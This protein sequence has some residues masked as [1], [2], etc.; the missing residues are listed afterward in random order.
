MK[1]EH[2]KKGIRNTIV[3][4]LSEIVILI[5]GLI[6]P[7]VIVASYGS[8]VNGLLTSTAQLMGYLSIFEAGISTIMSNALYS[9]FASNDLSGVC[10]VYSAGNSYYKKATLYYC[11]G[12]VIA[13][14]LY[15][16]AI[17]TELPSGTVLLVVLLSGLGNVITFL[18]L[19]SMK[20]VIASDGNYYFIAIMNLVIKT[21]TY[22]V[23]ILTALVS[24][25]VIIIKSASL[26]V[27][28]LQIVMYRIYFKKKYNWITQTKCLTVKKFDN[29][30]YYIVH[31]VASLL[32]SCT[33]VTL[34]TFFEGLTVVSIYTIYN[35]VMSAISTLMNAVLSSLLF[36][37]G[38]TY[39][40]DLRKYCKLHDS[41]KL[42]YIEINSII[43]TT[44]YYMFI[45]FINIYMEGADVNY[46][47][48][49][50]AIMF[51][52]ISILN[53]YRI[54]DNNLASISWH[55]KQTI[56]HVVIE[57]V[58]NLALSMI[59]VVPLKIYGVLIGT[60]IAII[61]RVLVSP[62][63]SE[64]KI[65]HRKIING[66]KYMLVNG[67]LFALLA[68][69]RNSVYIQAKNYYELAGYGILILVCMIFAYVT[70]NT[71][72]FSEEHK[73][74]IKSLL[75]KNI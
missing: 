4:I 3:S 55:A 42:C 37:L 27:T 66:Y 38:Q 36:A 15:T 8:E 18:F 54:I 41:F 34:L 11:I 49:Y 70:I 64:K 72:F 62:Y 22:G 6:V 59:L 16:F 33:D 65:L 14:F 25:D 61:Y 68:L 29:R 40:L 21:L 58:I 23:T 50:I 5:L 73:Y 10:D 69:L 51:C 24:L 45:P 60:A 28:V 19:Q 75:D 52:V 74:A 30:K 67:T 26:V 17:K 31:Q 32:F 2:M 47:D 7:R 48:P 57:A 53:S 63:Y 9:A 56:P 71:L 43:V 1:N 35:S 13:A 12:I 44:T 39:S 20:T 46:S